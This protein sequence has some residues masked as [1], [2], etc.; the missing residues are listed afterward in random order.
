MGDKSNQTQV[1]G[2]HY[3]DL[4]IQPWQAMEAWD[5]EYFIGFLRF[6]VVKRM[7][8]WDSKD[9]RLVDCKKAHHELGKLIEVLEALE[10]E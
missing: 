5:R 9:G 3:K 8:R 1:G 7:A 10:D 6:N 2:S 4:D